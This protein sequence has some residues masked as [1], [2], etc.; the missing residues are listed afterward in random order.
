MMVISFSLP[1]LCSKSILF[2]LCFCSIRPTC[3]RFYHFMGKL[4]G[5]MLCRV[6]WVFPMSLFVFMAWKFVRL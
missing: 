3:F 1:F 5:F 6:A 2:H 4:E